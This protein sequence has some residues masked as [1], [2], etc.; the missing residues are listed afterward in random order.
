MLRLASHPSCRR[1][2]HTTAMVMDWMVA[3]QYPVIK[4][5]PYLPDLALDDFF[6]FPK[7]KKELASITLTKETFKKEW[8]GAPRTV[9]AADLPTA[10]RLWYEHCKKCVD[11]AGPML[12]KNKN[13]H[14][15]I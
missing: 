3:R 12:K 14:V 9:K 2:V 7:V 10:F 8:E 4:H 5:P 15:S 11:I 1:V 13:K 6:L